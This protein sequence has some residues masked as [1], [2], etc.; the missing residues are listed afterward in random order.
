MATGSGK[1][2]KGGGW[3]GGHRTELSAVEAERTGDAP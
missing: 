2:S 3:G 1:G